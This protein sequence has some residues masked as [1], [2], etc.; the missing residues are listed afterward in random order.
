MSDLTTTKRGGPRPNSGR[1]SNAEIA[2]ARVLLDRAVTDQDWIDA[3]K[4]LIKIVKTSDDAR[5]QISAFRILA[6]YR[7][8]KPDSASAWF[9]SEPAPA[10]HNGASSNGASETPKKFDAHLT[11]PLD[12]FTRPPDQADANKKPRYAFQRKG[13]P[14]L[15][16]EKT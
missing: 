1:K 16:I 5:A 14:F 6:E 3:F 7:F 12:V 2:H 9:E 8:G 15:V 10:S 13:S 11:M 4:A